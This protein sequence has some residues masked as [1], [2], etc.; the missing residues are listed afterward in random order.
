VRVTNVLGIAR[1][2][3]ASLASL[4]WETAFLWGRY[5]AQRSSLVLALAQV[6]V[7]AFSSL[8]FLKKREVPAMLTEE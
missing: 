2:R 8:S 5:G 6:W 1:T 3:L 4:C 7:I